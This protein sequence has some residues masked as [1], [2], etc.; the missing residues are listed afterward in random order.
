MLK[1]IPQRIA[2]IVTRSEQV[3][4]IYL[5][6]SRARGLTHAESDWDIALLFSRWESDRL[7]ALLRPQ[8]IEALLQRELKLYDRISV[9]DL[10]LVPAPLQ[11]NIVNGMKLYDRGVPHVRRIENSIASK[12]EIDYA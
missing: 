8:T 7:E 11:F 10:A 5:Y 4:A 6:G 12:I 1:H 9:V 2:D 3:D